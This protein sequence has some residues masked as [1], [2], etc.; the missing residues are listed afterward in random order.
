MDEIF[1]R[2]DDEQL[3]YFFNKQSE[4]IFHAVSAQ[5]DLLTKKEFDGKD[6]LDVAADCLQI[7][8]SSCTFIMIVYRH[9]SEGL[10]HCPL[11]MIENMYEFFIYSF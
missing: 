9:I 6:A 11:R 8:I 1:V 7:T 2:K 3:R 10:S 5:E 4:A